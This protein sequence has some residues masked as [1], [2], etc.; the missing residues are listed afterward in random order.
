ML[1]ASH[2]LFS[3][4]IFISECNCVF[5][6]LYHINNTSAEVVCIISGGYEALTQR[7]GHAKTVIT[8]V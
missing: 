3:M 7:K 8:L 5:L 2:C 6:D 1:L 4:K